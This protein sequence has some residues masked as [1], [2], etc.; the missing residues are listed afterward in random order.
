MEHRIWIFLLY[1]TMAATLFIHCVSISKFPPFQCKLD[2]MEWN[3]S[4]KFLQH[5]ELCSYHILFI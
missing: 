4:V 2:S 3:G 1:S 5:E